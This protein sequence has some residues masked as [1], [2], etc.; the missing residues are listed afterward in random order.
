MMIREKV[1]IYAIAF[2]GM[3]QF[4]MLFNVEVAG[5]S[6]VDS[7]NPYLAP[8][9]MSFIRNACLKI[10]DSSKSRK[11]PSQ[12]GS[13]YSDTS[14][15]ADTL[16]ALPDGYAAQVIQGTVEGFRRDRQR[17]QFIVVQAPG[18]KAADHFAETR[19]N[20]WKTGSLVRQKE[21]FE[22][23]IPAQGT[24][25]FLLAFSTVLASKASLL[26]GRTAIDIMPFHDLGFN[27]ATFFLGFMTGCSLI[28]GAFAIH[29]AIDFPKSLL[30][31]FRWVRGYVL[32]R[33]P[34]K[35]YAVNRR[36]HNVL[37]K[38]D[39]RVSWLGHNKV[40][41]FIWLISPT[42]TTQFIEFVQ[43]ERQ[44]RVLDSGKWLEENSP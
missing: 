20:G 7:E 35:F 10:W 13:V 30:G 18:Q 31:M 42:D 27:S 17:Y 25:N 16:R 5:A 40:S 12:S 29:C 22:P 24:H 44:F 6:D 9:A 32:G 26:F 11:S 4:G 37:N 33:N 39:S 28:T 23:S 14:A 41:E 1:N 21:F 15:V 43:R 8:Q 38:L 2:I 34:L 19:L 36:L 3:I